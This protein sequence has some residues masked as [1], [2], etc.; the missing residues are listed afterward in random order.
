M[1]VFG[2]FLAVLSTVGHCEGLTL[3]EQ[4]YTRFLTLFL[5]FVEFSL[6]YSMSTFLFPCCEVKDIA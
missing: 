6:N 5:N 3:E 2:L 4:V 1:V